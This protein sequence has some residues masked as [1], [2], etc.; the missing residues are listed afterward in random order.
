MILCQTFHVPVYCVD[1]L[2]CLTKR[3]NIMYTVMSP[4]AHILC[5]VCICKPMQISL[6]SICYCMLKLHLVFRYYNVYIYLQCLLHHIIAERNI[7]NIFDQY[8]YT[9][10]NTYRQYENRHIPDLNPLTTNYFRWKS[11]IPSSH[12]ITVM[13]ISYDN[14]LNS[15]LCSD[16]NSSDGEIDESRIDYST[17]SNVDPDL[18]F[19]QN[20]KLLNCNYYTESEFNN[21][22]TTSNTFSIYHVNIRSLP[23][24]ICKLEYYL[25]E[26]TRKFDI[27]AISESWLKDYNKS[28]YSLRGYNHESVIRESR[29]GGGVS[30]YISHKLNYTLRPEL[31]IDLIDVN[32][33]SIEIPKTEF[34]TKHNIVVIVCYRAP[35]VKPMDFIDKLEELLEKLQREKS[36]VYFT[37]D[38]N[39]NTIK[40]SSATNTTADNYNNLFLSYSYKALIDKVTRVSVGQTDSLIDHMYTNIPQCYDICTTAIMKAQLADHYSIICVTNITCS[41]NKSNTISERD[42]SN[43]NKSKLKKLLKTQSWDY[44]YATENIQSAF[45]YFQNNFLYM[46]EE[47]FPEISFEIKYNNRLPFVT[48]GLRL[49]IERKH[50][51]RQIFEKNSTTENEIVYK[52]HRNKLTSLMRIA[53]RNYFEEQLELNKQ[54]IRKS[55]KT[56]KDIIG[57]NNNVTNSTMNYF[58]NGL[59]TN[60]PQIVSDAFN[61][62]FIEIGPKLASEITTNINPMSYVTHIAYSIYIPEINQH[63]VEIVINSLKNGSPG[64][65]DISATI[66]KP[67]INLYI[68]PLTYLINMSIKEGIFPDEMK[69]AKVIPIYKSGNKALTCNYR[70]ISVLNL[71]SKVFEKI[72]YNHLLDFINEHNILYSYQFGFRQKYSTNHAIITLVEKINEALY[73]GNIMIGVYIDLKKAFD[74]VNHNILL[75]KLYAYG[76]RGN[77]LKWFKSYL[78]NRQQFVYLNKAKSETKYVQCGV[79]QGSILGPYCLSYT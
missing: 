41:N 53:E 23:R 15:S 72:M 12:I 37:G 11:H 77:V 24:N 63:E 69:I 13:P 14:H 2:F 6:T 20:D 58:I 73:K 61:D 8:M 52:T 57:K 54:D 34:H 62:Y 25:E 44:I 65:D 17:L 18:N 26:I 36:Y 47:S 68:K 30:L 3:N 67:F 35:H 51:L 50:K 76:I 32:T 29:T 48:R 75:T 9:I 66:Y 70:P 49:S 79:P 59:E 64:W 74:T 5:H 27:I 56:I 19:M 31:T 1:D 43:K 46:F 4:I 7:Y 38:I 39:I 78:H 33:L 45:T 60:D 71:F 40:L 16:D 55:W 10:Y 28:L 21:S 42:F 22:F